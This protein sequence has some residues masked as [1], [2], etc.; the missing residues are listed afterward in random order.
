MPRYFFHVAN[1]V[2]RDTE[3]LDFP[4]LAEAKCEAVKAAGQIICEGSAAFWDSQEWE[5]IVT[6]EDGLTLFSLMFIGTEAPAI[7]HQAPPE[8]RPLEPSA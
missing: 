3:G 6:N 8:A 2:D 7:A 1:G 5:M 4:T